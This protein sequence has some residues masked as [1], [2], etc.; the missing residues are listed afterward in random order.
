MCSSLIKWLIKLLSRETIINLHL[1]T[2]HFC[3][4]LIMHQE[5]SIIL[6]LVVLGVE[7]IFLTGGPTQLD[8][9]LDI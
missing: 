1:L 4:Y 6:K 2:E 9:N 3:C 5:Y 7:N 8:V